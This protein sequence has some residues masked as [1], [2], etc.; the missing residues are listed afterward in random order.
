MILLKMPF[1]GFGKETHYAGIPAI[2]IWGKL[3]D[4][5]AYWFCRTIDAGKHGK[6][7]IMKKTGLA[8]QPKL[9]RPIGRYSDGL[10]G[11]QWIWN[12][13]W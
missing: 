1:A 4:N 6:K 9:M 7:L 13:V 12:L 8:T 11:Y 3:T 10:R 5:D 2:Y